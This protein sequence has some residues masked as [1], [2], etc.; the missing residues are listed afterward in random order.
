MTD[1]SDS[2]PVLRPDDPVR[3]LMARPVAWVEPELT[4]AQLATRLGDESVGAVPVIS[5]DRLEG[6]VSERDI[7][8]ALAAGADPDDVWTADVMA[9]PPAHADPD[10]AILTV[11][12][13]MLDEGVRHLPVVSD[14]QVV[15]VV[16]VRDALRVLADAWREL[17]G[18][19]ARR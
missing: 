17:A 8:R 2:D 15:G 3:L 19:P 1:D 13:R 7:V 16:S 6:V 18:A 14:G 11:A 9:R 10:D 5:G 4:L 12:E